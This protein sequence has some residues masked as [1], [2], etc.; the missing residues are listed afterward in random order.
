MDK[1]NEEFHSDN[2]L[3]EF[4]L[5]RRRSLTEVMKDTLSNTTKSPGTSVVGVLVAGAM[6]LE[7]YNVIPKGTTEGLLPIGMLLLGL[8][9]K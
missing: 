4:F 8:F 7:T 2:K 3:D 5:N 6:A 1:K 9:S